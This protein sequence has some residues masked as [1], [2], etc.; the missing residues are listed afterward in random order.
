MRGCPWIPCMDH[1]LPGQGS[2]L[3]HLR[4]PRP[5]CLSSLG[6]RRADPEGKEQV[7]EN[8]NHHQRLFFQ[9]VAVLLSVLAGIGYLYI[10]VNSASEDLS[11]GPGTLG[12]YLGLSMMLLSTAI[13]NICSMALG[14]R[15][16]QLVAAKIQLRVCVMNPNNDNNYFP[17]SFNPQDKTGRLNWMPE[18]HKIF[19]ISLISVKVLLSL[20]VAFYPGRPLAFGGCPTGVGRTSPVKTYSSW[21]FTISRPRAAS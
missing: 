11:I 6:R 19:F 1:A 12:Y 9:I 7:A 21:S 15:R 5:S 14:F 17:R 4:R 18:F 2:T 16:D 10:R 20:S 13:A 3:P 8:Q